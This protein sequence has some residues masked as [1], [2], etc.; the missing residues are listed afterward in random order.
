MQVVGDKTEVRKATVVQLEVSLVV[1][2][3][4]VS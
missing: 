3:L 4:V 1:A 2:M